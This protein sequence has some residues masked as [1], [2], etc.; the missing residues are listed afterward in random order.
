MI[1]PEEHIHPYE[2]IYTIQDQRGYLVWRHGT[3]NT[4][5]ILHLEASARRLGYGRSL[6]RHLLSDLYDSGFDV[7]TVYGFTRER[8]VQAQVFYVGIGFNLISLK[9]YYGDGGSVMF[10]QKFVDLFKSL[11]TGATDESPTKFL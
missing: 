7:S 1:R 10:R 5:E 6:V 9:D 2:K 11:N 3:G 4:V 8:L